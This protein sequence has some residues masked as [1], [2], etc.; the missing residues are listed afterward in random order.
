MTE[1]PDPNLCP[2]MLWTP[3]FPHRILSDPPSRCRP[4]LLGP[5]VSLLFFPASASDTHSHTCRE[6]S[7]WRAEERK[8]NGSCHFSSFNWDSAALSVTE[9]P[10]G[11]H[12]TKGKTFHILLSFTTESSYLFSHP[13]FF[14]FIDFSHILPIYPSLSLYSLQLFLC[15]IKFDILTTLFK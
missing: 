10:R 4:D 13:V 9:P 6:S 5:E 11:Q 8:R 2:R 15:F 14:F 1:A 12:Q 7:S 3:V